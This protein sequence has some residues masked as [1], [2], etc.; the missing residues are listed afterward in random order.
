[1]VN[2]LVIARVP[3][4]TWA[5]LFSHPGTMLASLNMLFIFLARLHTYLDTSS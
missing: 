4:S 3:L 2:G 1:M 5:M